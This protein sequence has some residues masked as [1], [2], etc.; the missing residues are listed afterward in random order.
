MADEHTREAVNLEP[1][2]RSR[3]IRKPW[4]APSVIL[5]DLAAT[6]HGGAVTTDVFPNEKSPS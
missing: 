3:S 5:S 1:Q 4:R 6:D 2:Q